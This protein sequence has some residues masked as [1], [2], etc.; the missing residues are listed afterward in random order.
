MSATVVCRVRPAICWTAVVAVVSAGLAAAPPAT[1]TAETTCAGTIGRRVVERVVVPDGATCRLNGTT[2][3]HNVVIGP[4]E[5]LVARDARILGSVQATD[6]PRS[7]RLLDTD[8][9]GN[10]HVRGATGRIVIGN[11]GCT[12]DPVAG[13]NIHLI[14][15]NG[16]IGLCQMRIRGNL[17]VKHNTDTVFL[18]ENRVGNNLHARGNT[19]RFLRLRGNHVGTRSNGN[20]DVDRNLTAVRLKT[21]RVS[22]HLVCRGNSRV[23]GFGNRAAGG[24]R[25]QCAGLR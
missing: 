5:T 17:H 25:H 7:V 11:A 4:G 8:V 22:N 15:N 6:G 21:N 12:L 19:G 24:M 14:E 9:V 3:R 2:V 20:L 18:L 23:Q 1:A 13:N 10:I 16:P